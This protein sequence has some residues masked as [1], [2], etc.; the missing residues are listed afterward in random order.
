MATRAC[1]RI[2]ESDL[3]TDGRRFGKRKRP[4]CAHRLIATSFP[5]DRDHSFQLIATT[6]FRDRDQAVDGGDGGRRVIRES[7]RFAPFPQGAGNAWTEI[8]HAQV[9]D[10]LRLSAA[11]MSKRKIAASLG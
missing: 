4:A 11:G 2:Q 3:S 8:T 7:A 6:H 5:I 9:R 10:V 1:E